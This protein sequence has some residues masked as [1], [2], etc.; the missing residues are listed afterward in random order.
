VDGISDSGSK[1]I[2]KEERMLRIKAEQEARERVRAAKKKAKEAK[3]ARRKAEIDADLY[4]LEAE[5]QAKR[6]NSEARKR[7]NDRIEFERK[8]Q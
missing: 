6:A 5:G 3:I 7:A 8:L 4:K 1:N 2:A